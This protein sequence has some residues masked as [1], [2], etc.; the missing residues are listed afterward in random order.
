M[1]MVMMRK[2]VIMIVMKYGDEDS[3]DGDGDEV[4]DVGNEHVNG[5][6]GVGENKLDCDDYECDGGGHSN[7]SGCVDTDGDGGDSNNYSG[8]YKDGSVD[9]NSDDD[10][11]CAD[12]K[13]KFVCSK[14]IAGDDCSNGDGPN[15]GDGGGD[16]DDTN[17]L[18]V[19]GL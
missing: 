3:N 7:D 18:I 15:D 8:V 4:D 17:F 19:N 9:A 1:M 6:D 11:D 13:N 16:R 2:L 5:A 10:H 14:G 12:S